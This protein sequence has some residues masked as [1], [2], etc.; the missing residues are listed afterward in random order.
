MIVPFPSSR[1]PRKEREWENGCSG[2]LAGADEPVPS[3]AA[4]NASGDA[5]GNGMISPSLPGPRAHATP[6]KS[7]PGQD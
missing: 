1:T 7:Q 6:E 3:Q 2:T 4:T 5:S